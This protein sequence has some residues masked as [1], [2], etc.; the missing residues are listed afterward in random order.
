MKS[1]RATAA[2]PAWAPQQQHSIV[3]NGQD[4]ILGV[5]ELESYAVPSCQDILDAPETKCLNVVSA[6]HQG[7]LKPRKG[8]GQLPEQRLRFVP[9]SKILAETK[10]KR[11]I[12]T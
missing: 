7:P 3:A 5:K 9:E 2:G 6:N 12:A 10:S 11:T 4:H 1:H 8:K